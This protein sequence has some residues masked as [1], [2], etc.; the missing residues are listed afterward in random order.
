MKNGKWKSFLTRFG[1]V[2]LLR[3]NRTAV[4]GPKDQQE[5]ERPRTKRRT[6]P[7]LPHGHSTQSHDAYATSTS[8]MLQRTENVCTL[9]LEQRTIVCVCIVYFGAMRMTTPPS[10]SSSYC[11]RLFRRNAGIVR[12]YTFNYSRLDFPELSLNILL[13]NV[14]P[15]I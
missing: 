8:N 1:I 9:L 10:P 7:A 5:Q 4:A 12:A 3:Y 13:G 14:S 6:L 2:D 11:Y 15:C